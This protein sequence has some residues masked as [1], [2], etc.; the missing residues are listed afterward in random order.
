MS[1]DIFP[2]LKKYSRCGPECVKEVSEDSRALTP[3][4]STITTDTAVSWWLNTSSVHEVNYAV[5]E[6]KYFPNQSPRQ[7]T[8]LWNQTLPEL[9]RKNQ[10]FPD[11]NHKLGGKDYEYLA[12]FLKAFWFF[13]K[14]MNHLYLH[15]QC[16]SGLIKHLLS[17]CLLCCW[18]SSIWLQPLWSG[19]ILSI[20]CWEITRGWQ[21]WGKEREEKWAVA[22]PAN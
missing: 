1:T 4:A 19:L 13:P 10:V 22:L 20:L 12:D 16:C 11:N 3:V 6:T 14:L 17:D 15:P 8:D 7:S 9:L 2:L 5:S 21:D 18:F